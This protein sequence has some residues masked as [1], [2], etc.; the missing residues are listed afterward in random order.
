MT[1]ERIPIIDRQQWMSLRKQDIT[2][3]V[4]G[5]LLG[6][7]E[8][9][10]PYALWALKSGA[11]A[12]DPEETGPMKRGRLL[13]PVAVELLREMQPA[14][15]IERGAIYL[16]DT[17]ARL[18]AT[19][20]VFA[21]D[22]ER[23]L[24]VVQIKSVESGVF[25]KKWKDQDGALSPPLW[26]VVQG[27]LEAY[28][29]GAKWAAVAPMVVG[30]GVDLHIIDIPVHAG[31]I[32]RLKAET[33]SFWKRVESNDAPDADY[34]RDGAI[35]AKLFAS[36]DGSAIDLS[37][38]NRLPELLVEDERLSEAEAETKSRRKAVRAEII[39]K[40]GAAASATCRGW[41][42]AAKTV[43][44]KAYSVAATSYRNLRTS[45]VTQQEQA[46]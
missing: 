24:G 4:A 29:S 7:H 5:A 46:S 8:F 2:A 37:N 9:T 10:T 28:L 20:D 26:V 30:F 15:K 44:R 6:V 11:I 1:I 36:D 18:G 27:I 3:S 33:A 17:D 45:R 13:E 19:P 38:D 34:G 39:S 40:L 42:I 22:P 16:R 23:G 43:N 14:W 35:I 32:D 41:S 25:R 31:I 12:D 21:T